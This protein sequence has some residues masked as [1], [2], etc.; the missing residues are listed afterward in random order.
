MYEPPCYS[1]S[2]NK[3]RHVAT[4]A[5]AMG[6]ST[7]SGRSLL[8]DPWARD[9]A[10]AVQFYSHPNLASHRIRTGDHKTRAFGCSDEQPRLADAVMGGLG[11]G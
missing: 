3:R 2:V 10:G 9:R 8:Y 7:A 4:S 5:P 6:P 1:I 11:V